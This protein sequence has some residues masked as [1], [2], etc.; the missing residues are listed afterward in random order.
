MHKRS[1][2]ILD[3]CRRLFSQNGAPPPN[4]KPFSE[5]YLVAVF[6]HQCQ[7]FIAVQHVVQPRN[8]GNYT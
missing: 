8:A 1:V 6:E 3:S 4:A 7:L 5:A 2:C